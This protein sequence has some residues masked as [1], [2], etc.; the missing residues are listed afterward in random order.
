MSATSR[1]PFTVVTGPTV[2]QFILD[3][4]PGCVEV[5]AAAYRAHDEGRTVSPS[6]LFLRPRDRPDA[7][8]I[9]LPAHLGP[10][11]RVSGIKWIAS[12]PENIAQGIPRASAVLVLN[13]AE[14]GF[15]FACLEASI[16]SAA[17]TA[18][19]A[20][21]AAHHL[22]G[23]HRKVR[24]LGIVGNGFIARYVYQF[25]LGT[26]WEIDAVHLFDKDPMRAECFLTKV[27]WADRHSSVR[28]SP[29]LLSLMEACD[30]IVFS[31]TATCPHV[32]DPRVLTHRPIVL[33]ISL[34]DL[35]PQLLLGAWNVVDD[36]EHV[37][38]AETSP[39]LVE[40]LTGSRDF[41]TATLADIMVHRVSLDHTRPIIFSPFG[42]GGL[43]L[44]VAHWIYRKA[45]ATGDTIPIYGFFEGVES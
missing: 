41:V 6:S 45:I 19:S 28:V 15:P 23:T 13:D 40:Q 17:R 31:T 38:H 10:P 21:L 4:L 25:L 37:M 44:A 33:H 36:V 16:I 30:L 26:G 39:H 11:W 34:R 7:R 5:V 14:C 35:S 12:Y 2:R 43:D 1:L 32:H 8:I 3:D 9:A 20:V 29:D 24:A 27:C 18:A 22:G 42:L